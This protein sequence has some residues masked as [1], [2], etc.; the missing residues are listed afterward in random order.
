MTKDKKRLVIIGGGAAGMSAATAARRRQEDWEIIALE[1]GPHVSFILCGLPYLVSE[2]VKDQESLIVYTPEYFRTERSID[3]RT[4]QEVR[5]IDAEAG[6][7]EAVDHSTRQRVSIPYDKLVIAAGAHAVRPN[8]PGISLGGVFT[9]RSLQ[10]GAAIRDYIKSHKVRRAALI[11]GGYIGLEMAEALR[12]AGAEVTIVEAADSL[13]PG[14][15]PPIAELIEEEVKRNGVAILKQQLAVHF[16]PDAEGTVQKVVTDQGDLEADIVIV[17]V[18]A[19]PDVAVAREAGIALGETLAIATDETMRTNFPNIYAAGDCVET[20]NLITGRAVYLPLGTTANK[21]GRVAGENAVGGHATFAGIVGTSGVK[22]FDLE[23]ARSGL[24][25]EQAKAAGFDAVAAV[26]RFPSHARFYPDAKTLTIKLVAERRSGRLLGAQMAGNDT[27]AKRIDVIA[28]ALYAKMTV[29]D[30]L[31][32]D[33]TYA[34]PFATPA[35]G[36]Q[37]AAQSLQR[38]LAEAE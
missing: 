19:R 4:G 1:R 26:T 11:G 34:P 8:I 2:I 6:V 28:T 14:S 17:A 22:V 37:L 10:S 15:E 3:V 5:H 29:A 16:E 7:V 23:T 24:S 31:R 33:L 36:I 12:I 9:L 13:M 20:R 21:Q 32:L 25:E 38:Q 35:E 27:V 18:G 30:L